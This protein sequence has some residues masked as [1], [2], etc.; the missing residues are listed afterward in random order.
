MASSNVLASMIESSRLV[1]EIST[2]LSYSS[3]AAVRLCCF[4]ASS[5]FLSASACSSS[6]RLLSST[7]VTFGTGIDTRVAFLS[8]FFI[9]F[10][11]S[12]SSCSANRRASAFRA[13]ASALFSA[14]SSFFFAARDFEP[15]ASRQYWS[16][17]SRLSF[18]FRSVSAALLRALAASA[19]VFTPIFFGIFFF[20]F[21]FFFLGSRSNFTLCYE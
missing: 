1:F 4:L 6:L 18:S 11:S 5:A 20:F 13:A 2:I 7:S 14:S 17:F 21:F 9:D 10:S 16:S 3:S 15:S 12:F 8:T 19:F